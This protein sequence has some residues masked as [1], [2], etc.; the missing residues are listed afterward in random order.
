MTNKDY[1]RLGGWDSPQGNAA[2]PPAN[3]KRPVPPV[4]IKSSPGSQKPSSGPLEDGKS[5]SP[6]PVPPTPDYLPAIFYGLLFGV[7]AVNLLYLAVWLFV[8]VCFER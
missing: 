1:Q 2:T 8:K 6:A 3:S 4:K 7:L 5:A